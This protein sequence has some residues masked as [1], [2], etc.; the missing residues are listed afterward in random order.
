MQNGNT[1]NDHI[2]NMPN[3]NI[4]QPTIGKT[5]P[6][7]EN[8]K[9]QSL[10]DMGKTSPP[11]APQS[12]TTYL[13]VNEKIDAIAKFASLHTV[14]NKPKRPSEPSAST[15]HAFPSPKRTYV[16]TNVPQCENLPRT[17]IVVIPSTVLLRSA[18]ATR[19]GPRTRP[20]CSAVLV[21]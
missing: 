10:I 1:N 20:C 13:I 21:P 7:L 17:Q 18:T 14:V 12:K 9:S 19:V 3:T 15:E 4:P 5:R 16:S 8:S 11:P 2:G 6:R